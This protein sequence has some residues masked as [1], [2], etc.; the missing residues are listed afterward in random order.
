[1]IKINDFPNYYVTEDGKIWSNYSRRF[2]SSHSNDRGYF[3]VQL[4]HEGVKKTKRVHRLVAMAF[5]GRPFK[6]YEDVDHLDNDKTNNCISNLMYMS[7]YDNSVK[8]R[9]KRWHFNNPDGHPVTVFN[10]K[11]YC[12]DFSLGYKEMRLVHYGEAGQHKGWTKAS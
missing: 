8:D 10:L 4:H 2:L 12:R 7:S 1:M 9:A 6:G 3:V 11:E 5:L